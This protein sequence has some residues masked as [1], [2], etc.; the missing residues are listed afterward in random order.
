MNQQAPTVSTVSARDRRGMVVASV[1]ILIAAG[2]LYWLSVQRG[3]ERDAA[4]ERAE[5]VEAYVAQ[6]AAD[7]NRADTLGA[8][9]RASGRCPE[10]EKITE[11]APVA[12]GVD[13]RDGQ[14]GVDGV[15]GTDGADGRDGQDGTDGTDGAPGTD[16]ATG[17]AGQPGPTP[18]F[19]INSEGDL[20]ASYPG[21]A[22][23]NLGRVRG[24]DGVDGTDGTTPNL[25]GYAAEEWVL[26][27]IRALG[28]ETTV[29]NDGPPLAFTCSITGQP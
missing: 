11:E 7:C 25:E 28:C 6:I 14:D 15:D 8:A 3:N 26:S 23:I 12:T 29:G 9:L 27:L 21:G 5:N 20:V 18:S 16:G 1:V 2:V 22:T 13:G 17:A 24:R 4:N 19:T 10:A